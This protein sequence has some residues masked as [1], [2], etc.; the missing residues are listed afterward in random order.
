M[1]RRTLLSSYGLMPAVLNCRPTAVR[2][3]RK[4]GAGGVEYLSTTELG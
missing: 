3:D 4:A 1:S 2:G